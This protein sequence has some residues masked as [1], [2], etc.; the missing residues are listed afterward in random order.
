MRF[1]PAFLDKPTVAE[2]VSLSVGTLERMV[3]KG[4]F[5]GPRKI[6]DQRVGWLVSEVD[7]WAASRP[8]S[9]GLP[10]ANCARNQ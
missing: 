4:A 3:Q 2:Y 1:K 8:R 10:V 5:P 6:S 7:D 9:S